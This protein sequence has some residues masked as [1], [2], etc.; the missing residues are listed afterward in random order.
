MD[1][2]RTGQIIRNLVDGNKVSHMRLSS[3]SS[4]PVD[5]RVG[6]VL[7]KLL[8]LLSSNNLFKTAGNQLESLFRGHRSCHFF[9]IDGLERS[10]EETEKQ[11][12]KNLSRKLVLLVS[13]SHRRAEVEIFWWYPCKEFPIYCVFNEPFLFEQSHF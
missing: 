6:L 7:Q 5:D 13:S 9:D 11:A 2:R 12:R 1:A 8:K 3:G 10:V 4:T